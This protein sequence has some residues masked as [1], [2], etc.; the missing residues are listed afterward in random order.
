MV[1]EVKRYCFYVMRLHFIFRYSA[2]SIPKFWY[3]SGLK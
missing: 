3:Y 2:P 1:L